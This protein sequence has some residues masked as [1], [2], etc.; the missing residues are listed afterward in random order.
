MLLCLFVLF[1]SAFFDGWNHLFLNLYS[2]DITIK[3]TTSE[4]IILKQTQAIKKN[5]KIINVCLC[6]Y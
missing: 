3:A 1:S 5:R 4:S 6:S 2:K